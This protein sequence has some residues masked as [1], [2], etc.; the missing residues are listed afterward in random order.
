MFGFASFQHDYLND[1]ATLPDII[2]PEAQG[3]WQASC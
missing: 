3:K 2:A 1:K